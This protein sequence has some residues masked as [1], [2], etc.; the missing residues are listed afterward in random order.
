MPMPSFFDQFLHG[1]TAQ[2]EP[3]LRELGEWV[4]VL[5]RNALARW[6]PIVI[7]GAKCSVRREKKP[8]GRAGVSKCALC[9]QV[10]CLRHAAVGFDATVVCES[11]LDDY[12]EVV[13]GKVKDRE[14][15]PE[16][17]RAEPDGEAAKAAA[18]RKL[19][20][21]ADSSWEEV[22]AEYKALAKKYHPDRHQ[23]AS[24]AEKKKFEAKMREINAAY[25][26]L[27]KVMDKP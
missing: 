24:A 2:L 19:G 15:E 16:P 22:R 27:E 9:E 21:T 12:S 8:C 3:V 11:C 7:S 14:A 18:L 20:L 10:V 23:S 25:T 5:Q 4:S 1:A 17:P 13:K 26:F 6:T